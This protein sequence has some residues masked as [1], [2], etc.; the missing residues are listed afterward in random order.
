M[1]GCFQF[2]A[3]Y[4][5]SHALDEISNS[6]LNPFGLNANGNVD[7]VTPLNPFNIRQLNYGSA[8]YDVR[9]SFVMNYVWSDALRH[10][11][12]RGPN[13]LVEAC[14]FSGT[15]FKHTG[16][17]YSIWSSNETAALQGSL[18]GSTSPAT[19]TAVL[20]N[21]VGSPNINCG[22]SA[23][24]LVNGQP[25]PCYSAA[26]FVDPTNNFGT[27]RRNQFRGPGYFDTDFDVE[28][29]FGIPRCDAPPS[30]TTPTSFN[31]FNHPTFPFPHP[32]I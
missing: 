29:T 17:P 1:N 13:E 15:I 12:P 22:A 3:S 28:K 5:Y 16:F 8:D 9:Q 32:T 21:V 23:A 25:N 24:Q 10:L 2:Q 30:S 26:N 4:T 7:V 14:T 19:T 18:F 20:A 31:L 27:Q 6:S 11:T